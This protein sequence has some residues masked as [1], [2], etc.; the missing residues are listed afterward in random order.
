MKDTLYFLLDKKYLKKNFKNKVD[1]FTLNEFVLSE[2]EKQSFNNI[3]PNPNKTALQSEEIII[4]TQETKLKIIDKIKNLYLFKDIK[5]LDEL[6]EPLLEIKISRF[7]YLKSIIPEYKK[8]ILI[9]NNKYKN[10]NT[11]FELILAIESLYSEDKIFTNDFYKRFYKF[12]CN[13]YTRV[14]LEIQIL[15]INNL[16]KNNKKDIYFISDKKAYF[17]DNLKSKIKNNKNIIL[18]YSPTNSF[19]KIILML[20]KQLYWLLRPKKLKEI[21][22]FLL[23]DNKLDYNYQK[24]SLNINNFFLKEFQHK[25]SKYLLKQLYFYALNTISINKYLFNLFRFIKLKKA[26]F[27]SI[28]FPDLFSFSRVLT[29]LRNNINLIS[30]GTHTIQNSDLPNRL[31]SRSMGIGL[32]FSNEKKVNLLSQSIYCDDFLDSMNLNYR[33]IDRLLN[34]NYNKTR[35]INLSNQNSKTK[36]LFIG[37]VKQLG[38]RRYYFESSAEFLESINQIYYKLKKYKDIFEISIRIRDVSYEID[39]QILINALKDKKDLIKISKATSIYEEINNCDCL[40]SF[41]STTLEEGLLMN[42]P[43]MCFGLPKYNHLKLYENE[44]I[45][46][47][48]KNLDKRLKIIES[49]LSR[50]FIY[51]SLKQRKIVNILK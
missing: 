5:D 46:S 40:I 22:I 11:R 21:G 6:L 19:P 15:L 18:Y 9:Y 7:F 34:K 43:V 37:T 28:R 12:K 27:H 4:K 16:L 29:N 48:N 47:R 24:I 50:K 45:E 30:H 41:S 51:K 3:F 31:A 49:A 38:A 36:I 1:L 44:N 13:F 32:S 14:F 25:Y 17:I 39:N 8:Y 35:N 23:P 20:L 26:Y 33:K 42:K 2:S 10:F